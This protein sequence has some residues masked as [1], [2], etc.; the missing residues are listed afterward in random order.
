MSAKGSDIF[1]VHGLIECIAK[2]AL[3]EAW[4]KPFEVKLVMH[5]GVWVQRIRFRGIYGKRDLLV[6]FD[7]DA[8]A[9]FLQKTTIET[10]EKMRAIVHSLFFEGI[11][12]RELSK[13]YKNVHVSSEL[14]L[15]I[16]RKLLPFSNTLTIQGAFAKI[17]LL[18]EI[19]I[20]TIEEARIL[21]E[22]GKLVFHHY[23]HDPVKR[24][25][26]CWK[27][28]DKCIKLNGF[29]FAAELVKLLR[30]EVKSR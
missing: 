12:Q 27:V 8:A 24:I 23:R 16:K 5:E 1:A 4:K 29:S 15:D 2:L 11:S 28:V 19:E 13:T 18:A 25:Q 26:L 22:I 14:A 21:L 17:P 30:E 9:T 3:Y 20:S 6:R 7:V 10:W